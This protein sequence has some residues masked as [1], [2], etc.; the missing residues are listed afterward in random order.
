MWINVYHLLVVPLTLAISLALPM[1]FSLV[2]I[3][4][5][6]FHFRAMP[7][8][9]AMVRGVRGAGQGVVASLESMELRGPG[10]YTKF[11]S[12]NAPTLPSVCLIRF[13]NSFVGDI[14][15]SAKLQAHKSIRWRM[16]SLD[17]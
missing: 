7:F 16:Y 13:Q 3:V 8:I 6:K 5:A 10:L 15:H 11:L 2:I 17:N 9:V 14:Q 4:A 12:S 1:I